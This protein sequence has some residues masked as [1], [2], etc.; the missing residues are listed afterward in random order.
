MLK[1]AHPAQWVIVAFFAVGLGF[2]LIQAGR[3]DAPQEMQIREF[4][5][6]P[7]ADSGR[8]KPL[9]TFARGQLILINGRSDFQDDEGKTQSATKWYL[10]MMSTNVFKWTGPALKYKI[11]RIENMDVLARLHLE[12]R[13][14]KWRYAIN[15]FAKSMADVQ[16]IRKEADGLRKSVPAKERSL[17]QSKLIELANHLGLWLS[18][19][20][21]HN[22]GLIPARDEDWAP[23]GEAVEAAMVGGQLNAQQLNPLAAH[24]IGE[25]LQPYGDGKTDRFNQ[26][27]KQYQD[28]FNA[29]MPDVTSTA[30]LEA[31]FNDLAPFYVCAVAY[32]FLFV[33]A[34]VS[35][36]GWFDTLNRAGFWSMILIMLLHTWALGIR[37]YILHRPPVINLYSAAV[38]IGWGCVVTCLVFEYFYRNS[39]ALAVGAATGGL[40][41][42][43]AHFLSL[44]SSDTMEM[45]RAVL[46]TNFW[47]ATHVTCVTLGYTAMFVSGFMGITY[48]AAMAVTALLARLAGGEG[49]TD[50]RRFLDSPESRLGA[51]GFFTRF[52]DTDASAVMGRMIYGVVC[53]AMFLSF[54]GT[55]LGGLW[56]D[57]SWGRFWGWDPKENG[58]LMIVIWSALILH[59]RWGGMV[60]QRGM[61]ILAVLGNIVTSWSM[62]GTNLLGIGLHAYGFMEGAMWWL[63]VFDLIMLAIVGAALLPLRDW[64]RLAPAT[65]QV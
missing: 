38:F 58:A 19:A 5:S 43:V 28:A 51:R 22:P 14:G 39:I 47:L 18:I 26:G 16:A 2:C 24:I 35:W 55:V 11:F 20:T 15:E 8:I 41:L 21:W 33:L 45:M 7:V 13:P 52:F 31:Y 63:G 34:V 1:T 40:S 61:A 30:R 42:I 32:G 56:A 48:I 4:G 65:P 12:Q 6:V 57:Y 53:F 17:Y 37:I 10:D 64:A 9:D 27:V 60:K 25:V 50:L 49:E 44:E 3:G 54:T 23:L 59:A 46:D 29:Q 62:F 36:L